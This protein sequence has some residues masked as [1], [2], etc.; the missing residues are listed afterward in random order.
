[1]AGNFETACGCLQLIAEL[2][3]DQEVRRRDEL[4]N[5]KLQFLRPQVVV[6]PHESGQ[7]NRPRAADFETIPG[8]RINEALGLYGRVVQQYAEQRQSAGARKR[9]EFDAHSLLVQRRRPQGARRRRPQTLAGKSFPD[10]AG[11]WLQARARI[12]VVLHLSA[13]RHRQT[14][15]EEL[16]LVL[17]ERGR[18][19]RVLSSRDQ[20]KTD[21]SGE[22]VAPEPVTRAGYQV[23]MR[24]ERCAVLRVDIEGMSIVLPDR[25]PPLCDLDERLNVEHRA[26]RARARPAPE[27]MAALRIG[28]LVGKRLARSRLRVEVRPQRARLARR[29]GAFQYQRVSLSGPVGAESGGDAVGLIVGARA[30]CEERWPTARPLRKQTVARRAER[31]PVADG[32]LLTE[33]PRVNANEVALRLG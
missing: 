18:K 6:P 16:D 4:A 22:G 19:R 9:R 8:F 21:V 28:R 29:E 27:Q 15:A 1:M 25:L 13:E 7:V 10:R 3:V 5:W 11:G 33:A 20:R 2:S 23:L 12:G 24:T 17:D 14:A 30:R 26:T 31:S 32:G